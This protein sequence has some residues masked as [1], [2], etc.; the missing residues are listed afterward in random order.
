MAKVPPNPHPPARNAEDQRRNQLKKRCQVLRTP[1]GPIGDERFL[2]DYLSTLAAW[3]FQGDEKSI[4]VA[5]RLYDPKSTGEHWDRVRR[6]FEKYFILY[7]RMLLPA[8]ITRDLFELLIRGKEEAKAP[9]L[10]RLKNPIYAERWDVVRDRIVRRLRREYPGIPWKQTF[11]NHVLALLPRITEEALSE[12]MTGSDP[13]EGVDLR[14]KQ[15]LDAEL[16]KE[17]LGDNWRRDDGD[18]FDHEDILDSLSMPIN[19]EKKDGPTLGDAIPDLRAD[20]LRGVHEREMASLAERM[21]VRARLSD[22]EKQ[23]LL[24]TV[25]GQT[26]SE[27]AERLDTTP[28]TV[29]VQLHNARKKIIKKYGRREIKALLLNGSKRD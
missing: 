28:V 25:D 24:L 4:L 10:D 23:I 2:H 7:M 12:P 18:I 8:T 29:R 11:S 3:I 14:L 26:D 9:V 19:S 6:I 16:P 1:P 17:I 21:M 13:S 22:R 15:K 5:G 27:I 20:I